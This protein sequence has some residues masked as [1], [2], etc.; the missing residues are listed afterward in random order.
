M[1]LMS[2]SKESFGLLEESTA[3]SDAGWSILTQREREIVVLLGEGR[4]Y[5]EIADH[6][7][8]SI[9]TVRQHLHHIYGKLKVT[10]KVEA[11]MA[12]YPQ[13]QNAIQARKN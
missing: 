11:I 1:Q 3:A 13:I 8:I 4:P 7:H 12:V 6:A 2:M 5:K 10:N 9:C